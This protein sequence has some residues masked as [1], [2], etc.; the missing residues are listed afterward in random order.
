M[1]DVE[2]PEGLPLGF[3]KELLDGL[4]EAIYF[5]DQNRRVLYWNKAAEALTGIAAAD[6][7]G[8]RCCDDRLQH[9][10]TG[11]E[12]LCHGDC[13]LARTIRDGIPRAE[14]VYLRHR[15]GHRIPVHTRITPIR[16]VEGRI[17]GA[18][19]VFRDNSAALALNERSAHLE[20]AALL[21]PLTGLP[22]RRCVESA[23][24]ARMDEYERYGWVFGVLFVDI[25][26]FKTV[27]DGYGHSV[28]DMV[29]RMVSR[30]LAANTRT[31]DILGRWGGEEFLAV[32]ANVGEDELCS[33]A[34]RSRMLVRESSLPTSRGRLSVTVSIGG[35][36][37]VP[38]DTTDTVV[39]RA[40]RRMYRSKAA[41][42]N[43][44]TVLPAPD[45]SESQA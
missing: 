27:N 12:S 26:R 40:D 7:I 2:R 3:Y 1:G 41:G 30:T 20:R 17:V 23:L 29:L 24:R 44:V 9:V 8:T 43:R 45:E 18:S 13:P 38:G 5:V 35:T 6:I 16:D 15:E 32:L 31:F 28:G 14:D 11:G 21:D 19:E 10:S 34:E 33:I 25:D 22:N 42:R 39:R 37:V 4:D 36:M